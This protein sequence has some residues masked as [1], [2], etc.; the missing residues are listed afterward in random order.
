MGAFCPPSTSSPRSCSMPSTR[1][2]EL[3]H[4]KGP[5]SSFNLLSQQ[6]LLALLCLRGIWSKRQARRPQLWPVRRSWKEL[7]YTHSV[8]HHCLSSLPALPGCLLCGSAWWPWTKAVPLG[9]TGPGKELLAPF[10]WNQSHLTH[11]DCGD[12]ANPREHWEVVVSPR[13]PCDTPPYLPSQAMT[14]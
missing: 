7:H 6:R 10:F 11:G 2:A 9:S 13:E 4:S 12:C 8:S 14:F 3:K 5:V 1:A